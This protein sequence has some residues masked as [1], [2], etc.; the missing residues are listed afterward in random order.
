MVSASTAGR[1]PRP[2]F[3]AG[4]RV[5]VTG[6]TGFKGSWLTIW[7]RDMGADVV[8]VGLSPG[9]SPS[10]FDL[11]SVGRSVR[12]HTADL[13]DPEAI[14][15]IVAG[16]RPQVVFHLAAQALVRVGYGDPVRT[17]DS[18][19]M[20]TVHILDAL[21]RLG[22]PCVV[23]AVT[24]DK[25]YR[26]VEWPY[27]YR[28]NDTLGGHDPYS[29]SKAAAELAVASFRDSFL[30]ESGIAV[31]TGRAGNVIGGGDWSPYRLMPDAIRAWEAGRPLLVRRPRAFRPWQH[32]LDALNGY[33]VLAEAMSSDS[34]LAEAWNF[35]PATHRVATVREVVEMARE[36]YGAGEVE[37]GT[38]D[39]GPHEAGQLMVEPSKAR[40][41]L[42]VMPRW[43]LDRSVARTM[44]WYRRQSRGESAHALCLSDLAAY[45]EGI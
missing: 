38:A 6:H 25:V 16:F 12:S 14:R 37:W 36:A 17:F 18:N 3:F 35:G 30:R 10:L 31:A 26:N 24:S 5:L 2:E 21:R 7:L 19:V 44:D 42:G 9:A 8:G 22:D 20:G 11:G 29:A 4:K 27:P 34:T 1:L 33:L 39:D 15:G 23:I 28:E 13:T 45:R 43:D 32:V 40:D 41:R